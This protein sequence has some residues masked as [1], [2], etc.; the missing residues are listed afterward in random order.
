MADVPLID[1]VPDNGA[2]IGRS[3]LEQVKGYTFTWWEMPLVVILLASIFITTW[4]G[5]GALLLAVMV[6]NVMLLYILK[7]SPLFWI[8][9]IMLPVN[10]FLVIL[11]VSQHR[12]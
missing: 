6:V 3:N 2:F 1:N 8:L 5:Q 4:S 7:S 12:F 9:L 11:L 10:V